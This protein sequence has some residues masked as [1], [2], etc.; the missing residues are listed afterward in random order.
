MHTEAYTLTC[1]H[2]G[3]GASRII[4]Q[5]AS[6]GLSL[7]SMVPKSLA[8]PDYGRC[9]RCKRYKMK[10]TGAPA[11]PEPVKPLGFTRIPTK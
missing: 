1:Q 8:D 7:G 9:L 10:I 5:A 11:P 6:A 3:C 2:K 4:Q